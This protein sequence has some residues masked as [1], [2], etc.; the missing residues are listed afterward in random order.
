MMCVCVRLGSAVRQLKDWYLIG[1]MGYYPLSFDP[2]TLALTDFSVIKEYM[3][4]SEVP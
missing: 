1:G 2:P 4:D 3:D